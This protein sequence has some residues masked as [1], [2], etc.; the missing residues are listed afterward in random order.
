MGHFFILDKCCHLTPKLCREEIFIGDDWTVVVN[1]HPQAIQVLVGSILNDRNCYVSQHYWPNPYVL[2]ILY[3]IQVYQPHVLQDLSFNFLC[4]KDLPHSFSLTPPLF[5]QRHCLVSNS[6]DAM[7]DLQWP[8]L[9]LKVIRSS[10]WNFKEDLP[11]SMTN[12]L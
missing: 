2:F 1:S 5:C 4:C 12:K 6:S 11:A 8:S 10:N 9:C 3:K 7:F